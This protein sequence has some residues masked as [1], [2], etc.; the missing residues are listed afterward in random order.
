MNAKINPQVKIISY[1][2]DYQS[3]VNV[4][5]PIRRMTTDLVAVLPSQYCVDAFGRVFCS[6][7]VL[8]R[9]RCPK[10]RPV[11]KFWDELVIT[12]RELPNWKES[13]EI[14]ERTFSGVPGGW[15]LR[16]REASLDGC[17]CTIVPSPL[18]LNRFFFLFLLFL[19][20]TKII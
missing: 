3:G 8:F 19:N 1:Y 9:C 15:A 10:M 5:W 13:W 20:R 12:V 18:F 17:S 7:R 2:T 14:G 11:L 4:V 16:F 6:H